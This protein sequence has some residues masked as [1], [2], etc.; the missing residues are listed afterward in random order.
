MNN[1]VSTS[2]NKANIAALIGI[3]SP[4][5]VWALNKWLFKG[6]EVGEITML[7]SAVNGTIGWLGVWMT[8][9]KEA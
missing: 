2:V 3:L 1:P 5:L 7:N 4:V 9:N 6:L 8:T